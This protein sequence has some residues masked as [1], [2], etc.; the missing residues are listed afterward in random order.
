VQIGEQVVL[1][2]RD[3]EVDLTTPVS[4]Q[5]SD[6][7][8][9]L[10]VDLRPGQVYEVTVDGNLLTALT[11]SAQGTIDFVTSAGGTQTISIRAS[12]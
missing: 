11:A 10:L 2:G 12:S 8:R 6:A 4:Y 9:N 5:V 7:A 1:F 3:G